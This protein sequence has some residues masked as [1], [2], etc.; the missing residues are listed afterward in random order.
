MTDNFT[1]AFSYLI[2]DEGTRFVNDPRDSGGPTKFGITMV[3]Y[4]AFLG[5][6]VTL[7]EMEELSIV[8]AEN[9]YRRRFWGP[10]QCDKIN[11]QSVATCL[12]DSAVLYGPNTAILLAQRALSTLGATLKFDGLPGDKTTAALNAATRA[13]FISAFVE[14]VMIRINNVI[15][16]DEK[17]E[18]FRV[19]WTNRAT[20]LL[21]LL[22]T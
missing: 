5:R 1:F 14:Q 11:D 12:F 18:R 21:S 16:G 15:A 9:F 3:S 10:L 8:N 4:S 19:G 6:P 2:Q 13:A 7:G 22:R 20:R 17:N